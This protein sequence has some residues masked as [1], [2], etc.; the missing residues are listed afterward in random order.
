LESVPISWRRPEG[1]P[2]SFSK[3]ATA[4]VTGWLAAPAAL[5]FFEELGWEAVRRRNNALAHAGQRLIAAEI[6]VAAS[7]ESMPGGGEADSYPIP[8]RLLPLPG[9]AP[10][11]EAAV[12]F[13]DR[14]AIDYAIECPVDVW[15]GQPLLRISAQL[16]NA[17]GDYERLAAAL[18]E[19]LAG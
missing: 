14:L 4:D 16:Y 1:F 8:M 6:G 13:T 2:H 18:K 9:V 10:T 3:I 12:A 17:I 11:R 7:L 19:I 5:K 15:N